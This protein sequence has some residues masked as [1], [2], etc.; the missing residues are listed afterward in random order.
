MG[1]DRF[2]RVLSVF[3]VTFFLCLI[4]GQN[5]HAACAASNVQPQIEVKVAPW[6][7]RYDYTRT[8][9]ELTAFVDKQAW[10]NNGHHA[11]GLYRSEIMHRH[12]IEFEEQLGGWANPNCLGV[13]RVS[14]ELT[15]FQPTIY[16]A[17]ELQ[18]ARCVANEVRLHEQKHARV[19]RDMMEW[20]Q[21]YM[22]GELAKWVGRY[23]MREVPDMMTGKA[24]AAYD[25]KIMINNAVA[26]YTEHRNA[27]QVAIDTPQEYR[28]IELACPN[29]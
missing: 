15:Y 6:E 16:L 17:K 8:Q 1:Y 22:Q 11:R 28:R 24:E 29:N 21:S 14:I 3:A 4:L 27:R 25:L 5:A 12:L 18:W 10:L 7:I 26:V 23:Q 20:M 9:A 19:D 13:S 2:L